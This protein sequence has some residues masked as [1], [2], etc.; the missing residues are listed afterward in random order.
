[1][2]A[3]ANVWIKKRL[4]GVGPVVNLWGQT[5]IGAAFLL[6]LSALFER[7]CPCI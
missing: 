2:S 1:V 5:M 4:G 7:A 6:G 3:F